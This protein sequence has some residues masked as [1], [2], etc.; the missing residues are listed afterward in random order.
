[1]DLIPGQSQ[2]ITKMPSLSA[3]TD[4][5]SPVDELPQ[6]RAVLEAVRPGGPGPLVPIQFQLPNRVVRNT[7]R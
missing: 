3:V 6:T 4:R 2:Y 5:Q 7:P 1:M